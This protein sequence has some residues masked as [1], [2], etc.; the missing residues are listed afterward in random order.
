MMTKLLLAALLSALLSAPATA[1]ESGGCGIVVV[2]RNFVARTT[3]G[4]IVRLKEKANVIVV[5]ARA[6]HRFVC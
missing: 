6:G 3:D 2:V 4:Q 5:K 1:T